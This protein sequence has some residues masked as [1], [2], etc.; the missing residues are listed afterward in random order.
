MGDLFQNKRVIMNNILFI[1]GAG[2]IGSSLIKRLVKEDNISICVLE[3]PAANL[4]RI[5]GLNVKVFR[6]TLANTERIE[7]IIKICEI[8]CI[9]HLVSTL[10]P[11]SGYEDFK[12]EVQKVVFPT[13]CLSQL[14]SKLGVKLIFFSSGGTVYGNRNISIPFAEDEERSPISYYGLTKLMIENNILFEH[15]TQGLEYLIL[16]P[17]NPYGYGQSLN[18]KQG[19]IAVALGKV[20]QGETIEIWGDGSSI[21]DYIYICDLCEI[22]IRILQSNIVDTTLNIGSGNGYSINK[23]LEIIEK[24]TSQKVSVTYTPARSQDVSTMILSTKKL[25]SFIDFE[26]TPLEVGIKYMHTDI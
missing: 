20:L 15:R 2:F 12:D 19:F 4:S 22:F 16:R 23:I 1:G 24:C 18:G 9:V 3:P 26:I 14:C 10:I 17:S 5:E 21:R 11:G 6:D 8:N 25:K 7:E 13:M